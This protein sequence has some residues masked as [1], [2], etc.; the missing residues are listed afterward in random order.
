MILRRATHAQVEQ[1]LSRELRREPGQ[2]GSVWIYGQTD[3]GILKVCVSAPV[4]GNNR[5]VITVAWPDG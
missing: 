3:Q 5:F 4:A 1:A 2:P